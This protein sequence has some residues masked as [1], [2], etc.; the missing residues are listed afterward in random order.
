MSEIIDAYYARIP[1]ALGRRKHTLRNIFETLCAH[2]NFCTLSNEK[3]A[4]IVIG[5]ERNIYNYSIA[6]SKMPSWSSIG[7]TSLYNSKAQ[8]VCQF[9]ENSC[10]QPLNSEQIKIIVWGK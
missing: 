10:A 6:K 3:K 9:L 2:E 5:I 8:F 4:G 7:F 1:D